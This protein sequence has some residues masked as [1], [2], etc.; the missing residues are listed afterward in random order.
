MKKK[1]TL[2]ELLVVI[3][4]IAILAGMLLPALQQARRKGMHI[5]CV[6]N[7]GTIGKAYVQYCDDNKG[8]IMPYYNNTSSSNSTKCWNSEKLEFST[9]SI[10]G[11]MAPYLGTT[12]AGTLGGWRYPNTYPQYRRKSKFTCPERHRSEYP[13]TS[14]GLNF[15]GQNN[16]HAG[17]ATNR[18][19]AHLRFPSRNS[20]IMEIKNNNTQPWYN[21]VDKDSIAYPHP[22]QVCNVLFVGGN[23]MSIPRGRIPSDGDQSFWR[24]KCTKNTW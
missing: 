7:F 16:A 8:I 11:M 9:G 21:H 20:A 1:F 14:S 19:L 15:L 12:L 18:S 5:T 6:N 4:I 24:P 22:N 23:V 13:T 10:A 2:I 3:A 17:S